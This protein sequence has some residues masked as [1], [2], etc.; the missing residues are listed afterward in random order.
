MIMNAKIILFAIL[1]IIFSSCE[2]AIMPADPVNLPQ[3]NFEELWK[4]IDEKYSF[5]ELK[6]ID[7]D[8]IKDLYSPMVNN[9]LSKA[10]EFRIYE[11]MLMNLKDG[12][13]NLVSS[14]NVSRYW[15]WM[16]NYSYNINEEIIDK[17]YLKNNYF[18]SGGLNFRKIQKNK[19]IYGYIQYKSFSNSANTIPIAIDYFKSDKNV[20]GIIIDIRNN[21]GGYI[22]NAYTIASKFADEKRLVL[23]FFYKNG[24]KHNDF[25]KAEEYYLEPKGNT[26]T[27]KPVILITNRACYSASSFFTVMMKE[28]PNVTVIGDK[29][30]G[31][32][33]IPSSYILPNGWR[34][35]FSTSKSTDARGNDFEMGVEPD[36]YVSLKKEDVNKNID[37][38]IEEAFEIINNKK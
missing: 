11:S 25:T 29:T 32:S 10:G 6:N 26:Y 21:G 35:R 24:K 36:K 9:S 33:G 14:F 30:G 27:T 3:K 19:N 17:V 34:I 28:L 4:I 38:I 1:S 2:K 20:K 16:T 15:N 23:K 8:N 22:D 18:I 13:V 12:H 37:S 31:G 5:F 7:W